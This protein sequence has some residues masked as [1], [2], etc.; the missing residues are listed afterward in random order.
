LIA[1]CSEAKPISSHNPLILAATK[2]DDKIFTVTLIY[3]SL[4][5]LNHNKNHLCSISYLHY[6]YS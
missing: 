4:E 3:F 2:L 5:K 1:F 6:E